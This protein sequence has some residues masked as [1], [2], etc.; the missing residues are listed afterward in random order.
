M[1]TNWRQRYIDL[2]AHVS[3]WSKDPTTKV[4]AIV[5]GSNPKHI[6]LG[7]NGFPPGVDDSWGRLVNRQTKYKYVIHAERNALD[8]ATFDTRGGVLATTLFPCC[9]CAKSIISKGIKCVLAP[10]PPPP[11]GEPSWRDD[12]KLSSEMLREAGVEIIEIEPGQPVGE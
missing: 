11:I 10:S 8:N 4:G 12:L 3:A 6:T 9:E 7:Y 2:A 5:I 1:A